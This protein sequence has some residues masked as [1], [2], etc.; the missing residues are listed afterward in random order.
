MTSLSLSTCNLILFFTYAMHVFL[1]QP[2]CLLYVFKAIHA[3]FFHLN[4]N[5]I[6][7]CPNLLYSSNVVINSIRSARLNTWAVG[8]LLSKP[9]VNFEPPNLSPHMCVCVCVKGIGYLLLC[10]L[11]PLPSPQTFPFNI[12]ISS[13]YVQYIRRYSTVIYTLA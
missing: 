1:N 6:Y 11:Y 13:M 10:K 2:S 7:I 8:H 12:Y 4:L 3:K 5:M 9:R